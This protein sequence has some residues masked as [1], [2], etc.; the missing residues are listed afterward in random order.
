MRPLTRPSWMLSDRHLGV[1]LPLEPGW[2][3]VP[4]RSKEQIR[5]ALNGHNT[6][7]ST[8]TTITIGATISSTNHWNITNTIKTTYSWQQSIKDVFFR[9]FQNPPLNPGKR[10]T[11]KEKKHTRQ[12]T[13]EGSVCKHFLSIYFC[14]Q[15]CKSGQPSIWTLQPRLNEGRW[16]EL[17][18]F[19]LKLENTALDAFFEKRSNVHDVDISWGAVEI[20]AAVGLICWVGGGLV[21]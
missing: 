16:R 4:Q 21:E 14:W 12:K 17:T 6:T 7:I 15:L 2:D 5:L 10:I 8:S 20:F 11:L 13:Q 3:W 1:L 18:S 9:M 19:H